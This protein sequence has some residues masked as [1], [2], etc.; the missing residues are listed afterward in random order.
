VNGANGDASAAVIAVTGMLAEAKAA[1]GPDIRVLS[2]GGDC[3]RLVAELEAAVADEA[4]A[5]ISFGIAGGLA[6]GLMPGTRLVARSVLTAD[7]ERFTCDSAWASKLSLAVGGAP[8]VDL[9]GVDEPVIGPA[10]KRALHVQTGALAVDMESH[11][12]ARVAARH[13]LPFVAFRVVA[14]PA[15]RELPH[16]ALVGMRPDGSMAVGAVLRSLARQP[17][18][19]P[20]LMRTAL[21]A[22]AAFS[23][24]FRSREMFAGGLGFGDLSELLLDMPAENIISSSLPV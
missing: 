20:Q 23:A 16:A 12:A 1:R 15:H 13:N 18:Q 4:A 2:G 17:R 3:E 6:P 7:G 19:I 11:I 5:I 10:A 8:I 22:R 9:I 21:D 24:L 14:D